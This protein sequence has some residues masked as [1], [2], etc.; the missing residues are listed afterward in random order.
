M[1]YKAQ[2]QANKFE[3]NKYIP[4]KSKIINHYLIIRG[5]ML[6]TY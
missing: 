6:L 2:D 3:I 5:K 4:N 1:E